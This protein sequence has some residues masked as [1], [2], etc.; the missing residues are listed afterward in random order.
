MSTYALFS[1]RAVC[2]LI[3]QPMVERVDTE[4]G[5][6]IAVAIRDSGRPKRRIAAECG[7][8]PQAVTKWVKTGKIGRDNLQCLSQ[9]TGCKYEWLNDG[10]GARNDNDPGYQENQLEARKLSAKKTWDYMFDE[11]SI[12]KIEAMI[13]AFMP[14]L[15]HG[16]AHPK[17]AERRMLLRR[18]SDVAV[19][20]GRKDDKKT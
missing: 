9:C 18:K 2:G 7:V 1:K 13:Q 20:K 16:N 8:S 3:S 5:Q 11:F 6:R 17:F 4:R 19:R 10:T 14:D 12:Q 15:S